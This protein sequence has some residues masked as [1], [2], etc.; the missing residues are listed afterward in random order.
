[1][2]FHSG[3]SPSSRRIHAAALGILFLA[4]RAF[5]NDAVSLCATVR[6]EIKQELTLERQAFEA[7]MRINNG[8]THIGLENIGVEVNFEDQDGNPVSAT[9]DPDNSNARFFIRLHS[10]ENINN[11]AGT[12]TIAPATSADIYWLIIPAPGAAGAEPWGTMYYVGASLN[13]SLGGEDHQIKVAPDYIYVKPM[14]ELTLEY[15]LPKDVYGDDAFTPEIEPPIPFS[16]GVLVSNSGFG[17]ARNLKI[18][19][20]Q[21]KIVDNDQGLLVEFAIDGCEIQGREAPATLLA[22][23]GNIAPESQKIARWHMTTSLSGQF[24]SFSADFT[25][26]DELG[27]VLTSLIRE[28]KTH[29]LIH[30]VQVD[31]PGRDSVK[32]FLGTGSDEL[33]V[34]ESDTGKTA[35]VD[36][37]TG[38]TLVDGGGGNYV[39]T[40]PPT[41]GPLY[42]KLPVVTLSGETIV[43]KVLRSDG[44]QISE[45][46]AWISKTRNEAHDWVYFFNLFDM[47][48]PGSYTVLLSAPGPTPQAP[49]LEAIPDKTGA[50]TVPLGFLVTSSDPNGTIPQISATMLPA[51]AHFVDRGD[52]KGNFDWTPA[53]GQAGVYELIFTATDG[54][55]ADTEAC[56]LTISPAWD[57]DGDGMA[58]DWERTRF[59][60]LDHDGSGDGDHDG[61]TDFAE[62]RNGSD[63]T[64]A[65]VPSVPVIAS[66]LDGAEVTQTQ[67]RLVIGNSVDSGGNPIEYVWEL[68]HKGLIDEPLAA[69]RVVEGAEETTEWTVPFELM[70]DGWYTIRVRAVSGTASDWAYGTFLV[71]AQNEAPR[72][73]RIAAPA[74]GVVV[75]DPTPLLEVT[76]SSDPDFDR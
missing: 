12:G 27:G 66:P 33:F 26:S 55:L 53:V 5:S 37:S 48:S 13:Y 14:P 75:A 28:V 29:T 49:V 50:E 71:N 24:V 43:A 17:V 23:F 19:S 2:K 4:Q 6:I 46:N 64:S 68:F 25:H 40:V 34:Y 54:V 22:D 62:Y 10:L 1:M 76:N 3:K 9:S 58:D 60:T 38:S 59:G 16:L 63:P 47:N 56:T 11:V 21:P 42:T 35:V 67:P 52:G 44:K 20:A 57:T 73:F 69:S 39:L 32:D 7:H 18:D 8:F 31:L 41:D 36:Q 70:E 74:D 15:F 30:D 65:T 51:G 45:N 72:A 61:V